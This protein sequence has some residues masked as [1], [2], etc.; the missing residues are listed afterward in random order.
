[1]RIH[2]LLFFLFF[3]FLLPIP[4]E[5]GLLSRISSMICKVRQGKC[6]VIGCTSKEEKIGTCSLGRRKCCRKKK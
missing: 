3:L 4:G 2:Y 1:M 6:R 5:S